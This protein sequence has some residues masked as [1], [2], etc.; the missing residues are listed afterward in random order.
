MVP[1]EDFTVLS[2]G[3]ILTR[4]RQHILDGGN[5]PSEGGTAAYF[6]K[7]VSL[8]GGIILLSAGMIRLEGGITPS[9]GGRIL[10][11]RRDASIGTY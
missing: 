10:C 6:W 8:D 9:E 2:R 1:L 4:G 11:G 7:A 3:A 5:M